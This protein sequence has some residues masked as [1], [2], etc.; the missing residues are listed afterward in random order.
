[1]FVDYSEIFLHKSWD[2]LND[3]EI[4]ELTMTPNFTKEQQYIFFDSLSN[5]TNYFI[6]GIVYDSVLIGVCGLKNITEQDGEY[7]GYIGEK[8]YWG[9]GI[10]IDIIDFIIEKAKQLNLKSLY[11]NVSDANI[12]AQRL[13]LK[14][15]FDVESR[16]GGV[17]KMTRTI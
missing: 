13:Y 2:W 7:W 9:K 8:N 11:L 3:Q 6:K 15:G 10:G 12:R 5:R 16:N 14:K 4:K 1:M 17:I